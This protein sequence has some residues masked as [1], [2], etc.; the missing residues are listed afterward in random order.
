MNQFLNKIRTPHNNN[1]RKTT[2]NNNNN[3]EQTT[4][5]KQ[6][7]QQQQLVTG[8]GKD[9]LETQSFITSDYN[10]GLHEFSSTYIF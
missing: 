4:T 1:T 3:N 8:I 7:Q 9:L 2:N 5:N 6:Q 10:Y